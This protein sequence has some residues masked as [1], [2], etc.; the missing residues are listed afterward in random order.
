MA[1]RVTKT[2][3]KKAAQ[4]LCEGFSIELDGNSDLVIWSDETHDY[5]VCE[6]KAREVSAVLGDAPIQTNGSWWRIRYKGAFIDRGDWNDPSSQH[7]Y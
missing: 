6:A 4:E 7:H 2:T 5:D 3:A 1:K